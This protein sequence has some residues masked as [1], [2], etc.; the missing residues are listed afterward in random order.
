MPDFRATI[1]LCISMRAIADRAYPCEFS[2][3]RIKVIVVDPH[4][5]IL[6]YWFEEYLKRKHPI[7]VVRIDEHH[8][9]HHHCQSLPAREGKGN[10]DYLSDL[11][12][13]LVDYARRRVNEGN[14]TCPAFH[15]GVLG[16][17]YHLNPRMEGINA[18]GR[19]CGLKLI[20]APKTKEDHM[21]ICGRRSRWIVWD[22]AFTKLK[23]EC[24]KESPVPKE[25]TIEDFKRDLCQS[26]YPVSVGFDLDG[27]YSVRDSAPFET[28]VARRMERVKSLLECVRSPIFICIARSQNPR[29]YV[30]AEKVGRLQE[31]AINLVEAVYG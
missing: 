18:Y 13:Y 25:I 24:G 17:L 16:A 11:M 22:E 15:Y 1:L 30:P 7:V 5:D 26:L 9:M 21:M 14:F 6:P 2:I 28:A 31:M 10:W 23:K 29:T 27:L 19:V 3:G 8:D 20:D 12:S 4:S